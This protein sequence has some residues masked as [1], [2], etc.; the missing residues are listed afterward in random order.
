MGALRPDLFPSVMAKLYVWASE[1]PPRSEPVPVNYCMDLSV[2]AWLEGPC[3]MGI[4]WP[5]TD[6]SDLKPGV[7]SR[8]L[9]LLQGGR[10]GGNCHRRT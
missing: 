7:G 10:S 4:L 5:G 9:G 3:G 2:L 8:H 6:P 1:G